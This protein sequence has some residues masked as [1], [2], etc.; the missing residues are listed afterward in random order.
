MLDSF[1]DDSIA[2]TLREA[3]SSFNSETERKIKADALR[4]M[5]QFFNFETERKSKK[6]KQI[7]FEN[8]KI[9]P[10]C[11]NQEIAQYAVGY[12][13]DCGV[14]LCEEEVYVTDDDYK[15]FTTN[16]MWRIKIFSD[17]LY[18]RILNKWYCFSCKS[19][20]K[21]LS[22]CHCVQYHPA[23]KLSTISELIKNDKIESCENY[24][25][26]G[27]YFCKSKRCYGFYNLC[28]T[29]LLKEYDEQYDMPKSLLTV[30]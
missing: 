12:V 27:E 15:S 6:I 24:M 23:N 28:E 8:V 18:D 26:C 21:D 3:N 7:L 22:S 1:L 13:F 14:P 17:Y 20:V 25:E 16:S 29:C 4:K 19:A 30:D 11:I 10:V 5:E 9:L 2:D